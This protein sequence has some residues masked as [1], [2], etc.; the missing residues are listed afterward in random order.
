M[1]PPAC[2]GSPA[3]IVDGQGAAA[4]Q[5]AADEL[6]GVP[7]DQTPDRETGVRAGW[8]WRL[9]TSLVTRHSN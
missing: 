5:G 2:A 3:G 9:S 6:D 1:T 4:G 7:R 8:L